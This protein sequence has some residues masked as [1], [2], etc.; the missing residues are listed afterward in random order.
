MVAPVLRH[1]A[2]TDGITLTVFTQD[3]LTFPEGID[4]VDDTDLALSWHNDIETV[5]TL[6]VVKDGIEV[7]RTVGWHRGS[8]E[9]LTGVDGLGL[10]GPEGDLPDQRPGCGSMS[11]DPSLVDEL[12]VRYG[13]SVLHSRRVEVAE[14]ED[15]AEAMFARGW[16]DGLPVVAP[17]EARVLRMPE[18][19]TRAPDEGVAVVP[20][21]PRR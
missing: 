2:A 10:G 6:L 8:W 13:G 14:L 5:P 12:R 1:L 16:T 9:A 17:T 21:H 18:G 15:E 3:D 4:A 11:V 7:D 19:N 20:P